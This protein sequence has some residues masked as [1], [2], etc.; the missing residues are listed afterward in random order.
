[1]LLDAHHD[2][3]IWMT[4][5]RTF[6][7]LRRSDPAVEHIG[8]HGPP[9]PLPFKAFQVEILRGRDIVHRIEVVDRFGSVGDLHH[10]LV[11]DIE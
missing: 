10:L 7:P 4:Q 8:L 5:P 9:R 3:E 1:M 6:L 2:R 11:L